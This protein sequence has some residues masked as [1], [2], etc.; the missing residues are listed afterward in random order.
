MYSHAH[1]RT[2]THEHAHMQMHTCM[3]TH[4]THTHT[5]TRIHAHT[6]THTRA[7]TDTCN[8][9]HARIHYKLTSKY[10]QRLSRPTKTVTSASTRASVLRFVQAA[11][12]YT[13][14]EGQRR[15]RVHTLALPVTDSVD[16]V[17]KGGRVCV[18]ACVH[19]CVCV[20]KCMCMCAFMYVCACRLCVPV[21]VLL[22][23]VNS[24]WVRD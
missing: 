20:R 15:V 4:Y 11:L 2:H 5:R 22:F 7:R 1:T 18:C 9:T 12:L 6:H 8:L 13:T 23:G 3:H 24:V 14:S 16:N 10:A 19:V 17:F 21:Y